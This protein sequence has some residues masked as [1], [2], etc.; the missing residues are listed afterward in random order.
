MV[1]VENKIYVLLGGGITFG[2]LYIAGIVI[3]RLWFHPLAKYPGPFLNRVSQV[4][5]CTKS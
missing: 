4:S 2:I 3:Y 1:Y 5:F